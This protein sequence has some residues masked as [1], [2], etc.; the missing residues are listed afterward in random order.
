MLFDNRSATR[1]E[2][3]KISE[4]LVSILCEE[5]EIPMKESIEHFSEAEIL[6]IED[7]LP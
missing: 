4:S 2:T 5:W 7:R 1:R 6:F 3:K